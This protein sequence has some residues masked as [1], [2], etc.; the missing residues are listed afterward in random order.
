MRYLF[1]ILFSIIVNIS[2][3]EPISFKNNLKT[4]IPKTSN[5]KN[6]KKYFLNTKKSTSDYLLSPGTWSLNTLFSGNYTRNSDIDLIFAGIDRLERRDIDVYASVATFIK[7]NLAFGLGVNFTQSNYTLQANILQN[8]VRRFIQFGS[9]AFTFSPFLKN[10][11]PLTSK[12]IL[13]LTNRTELQYTYKIATLET[14]INQS[15]GL[16]LPV[17]GIQ[18]NTLQ[19]LQRKFTTIYA[20]G[21]SINPGMVLFLTRR[22]AFEMS[23][24][25]LSLGYKLEQLQ[26]VYDKNRPPNPE[27]KKKNTTNHSLDMNFYIDLLKLGIGFSYYL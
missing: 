6:N 27:N 20:V 17:P 16:A 12:H 22:F 13:Y 4:K 23:I 7:P 24:G 5:L 10:Y 8:F 25:T 2:I 26:Y 19:T 3:A 9:Q 21:I 1:S 14:P 11:V 18:Q 15:G